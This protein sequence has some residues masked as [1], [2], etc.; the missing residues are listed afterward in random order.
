MTSQCESHFG[1]PFRHFFK[2]LR[3]SLYLGLSI[4]SLLE[5]KMQDSFHAREYKACV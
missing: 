4:L 5:S 1:G 2:L 3:L